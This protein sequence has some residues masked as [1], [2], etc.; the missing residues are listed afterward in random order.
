MAL[1]LISYDLEAPGRNYQGLYDELVHLGAKKLMRTQW[2]LRNAATADALREHLWSF[3]D[4]NDR[5][6]VSNLDSGWTSL[7][8]MTPIKGI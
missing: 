3:M 6:L 8:V 7:N 2:A 1:H 4:P 5:L